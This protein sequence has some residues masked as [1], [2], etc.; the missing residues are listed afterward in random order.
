VT[1]ALLGKAFR[2]LWPHSEM[3]FRS[4]PAMPTLIL[5]ERTFSVARGTGRAMQ[6]D[7]TT[8]N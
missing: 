5:D 3:F 6:P 8:H 2:S 7:A 4:L 1:K